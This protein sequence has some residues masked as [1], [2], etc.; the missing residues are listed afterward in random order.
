MSLWNKNEF[1]PML[2]PTTIKRPLNNM[3]VLKLGYRENGHNWDLIVTGA[4]V[5]ENQS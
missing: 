5:L 1:M 2:N 3:T 4:R